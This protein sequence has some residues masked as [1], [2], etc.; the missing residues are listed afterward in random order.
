MRLREVDGGLEAG[1]GE[2]VG[3]AGILTIF[4][5]SRGAVLSRTHRGIEL[6]VI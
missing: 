6:Y 4:A 2:G 5:E 3:Q 1:G